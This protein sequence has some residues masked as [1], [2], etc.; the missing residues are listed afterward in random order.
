MKMATPFFSLDDVFKRTKLCRRVMADWSAVAHIF[1]L[2]SPGTAQHI[3]NIN[4]NYK[5]NSG[6][7]T[8][9]LSDLVLVLGGTSKFK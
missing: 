2:C 1:P 9:F 6:C 4:I 5:P 7:N 8:E 3:I